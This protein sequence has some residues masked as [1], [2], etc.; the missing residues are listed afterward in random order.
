MKLL[1]RKKTKRSMHKI[2]NIITSERHYTEE[3]SKT[4]FY[5]INYKKII[6]KN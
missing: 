6:S 1:S 4:V 3:K 2:E 5:H